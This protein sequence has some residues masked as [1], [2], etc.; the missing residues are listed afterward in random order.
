MSHICHFGDI[1]SEYPDLIF[2][3]NGRKLSIYQEIL[4]FN[5]VGEINFLLSFLICL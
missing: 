2:M 3:K 1:N 4:N 5:T